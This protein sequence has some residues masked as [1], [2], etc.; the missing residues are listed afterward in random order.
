MRMQN[1]MRGR[2]QLEKIGGLVGVAKTFELAN[3]L[4]YWIDLQATISTLQLSQT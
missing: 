1:Y 3:S 2:G 4:L